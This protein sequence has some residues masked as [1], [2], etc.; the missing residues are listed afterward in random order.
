MVSF[1][2]LHAG[3]FLVRLF[4]AVPEHHVE[5]LGTFEEVREHG[6]HVSDVP[7]LHGLEGCGV[8]GGIDELELGRNLFGEIGADGFGK[9]LAI[10]AGDHA[11]GGGLGGGVEGSL[12]VEDGGFVEGLLR[13][14]VEIGGGGLAD[15]DGAEEVGGL[16]NAGAFDLPEEGL[17][18]VIGLGLEG[19]EGEAGRDGE[20]DAAEEGEGEGHGRMM[21]DRCE[22]ARIIGGVTRRRVG[23]GS[24]RGG[25]SGCR[26]RPGRG[27][28]PR[29]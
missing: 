3:G 8:E 12:G 14:G 7:G 17:E 13:C 29:R 20:D 25:G 6:K 19:Q 1:R 27:R 2:G 21:R 16:L 28:R 22:G 26:I 23:R 9:L 5:R 4:G 10:G 11:D 15:V 18:R 24:G